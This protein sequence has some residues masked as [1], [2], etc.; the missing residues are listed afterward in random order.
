MSSSDAR[1]THDKGNIMREIGRSIEAAQL[2]KSGKS[3]MSS[4][5]LHDKIIRGYVFHAASHWDVP[6]SG[7]RSQLSS[8]LTKQSHR[9]DWL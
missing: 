9:R 2:C 6:C 8:C 4:S 5:L 7:Q 3:R 1:L